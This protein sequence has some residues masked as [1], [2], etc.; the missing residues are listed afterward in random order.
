MKRTTIIIVIKI[1]IVLIS[2]ILIFPFVLIIHAVSEAFTVIEFIDSSDPYSLL[3]ILVFIVAVYTYLEKVRH[4]KKDQTKNLELMFMSESKYIEES[5]KLSS[6]SKKGK[7][8]SYC[9]VLRSSDV[10]EEHPEIDYVLKKLEW[11]S[12]GVYHNFYDEDYLFSAYAA[13]LIVN[14]E[15][16]LP[17]ILENQDHQDRAYIKF[18]WLASKWALKREL[19][20]ERK[21][22]RYLEKA[23][24]KINEYI[25]FEYKNDLASKVYKRIHRFFCMDWRY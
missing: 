23:H 16:T 1:C 14:F 9:D 6:L 17:H 2:I 4:S 11:A 24:L 21:G 3:V 20:P 10:R 12:N 13:L 18:C 19:D 15:R 22:Y 8:C 5:K 25:F 7:N